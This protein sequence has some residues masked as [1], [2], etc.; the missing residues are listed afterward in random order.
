MRLK[1][2]KSIL[3]EKKIHFAELDKITEIRATRVLIH[4]SLVLIIFHFHF[5]S[6]FITTI[7]HVE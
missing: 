6:V 2:K 5:S 1:E 4:S 3:G 7:L